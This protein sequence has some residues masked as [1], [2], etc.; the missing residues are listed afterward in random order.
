MIDSM[1]MGATDW[2]TAAIATARVAATATGYTSDSCPSPTAYAGIE[3]AEICVNDDNG[4]YTCLYATRNKKT[5][6]WL[7]PYIITP[8][9]LL[10]LY[11]NN[12][13]SIRNNVG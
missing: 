8:E 13:I 7:L 4:F 10:S 3:S 1:A 5:V 9:L 6:H 2:K 11:K 12:P